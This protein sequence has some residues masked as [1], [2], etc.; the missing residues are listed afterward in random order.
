MSTEIETRNHGST[1]FS[2]GV[3]EAHTAPPTRRFASGSAAPMKPNR[4]VDPYNTSGC[5]DRNQAW[6]SVGKR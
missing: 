5:F 1:E 6:A 2:R 3:R 4:G